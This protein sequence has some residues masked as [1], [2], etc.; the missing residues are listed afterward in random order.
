MFCIIDF[1]P[2]YFAMSTVTPLCIVVHYDIYCNTSGIVQ[3]LSLLNV[4]GVRQDQ[5]M[6][7]RYV[8]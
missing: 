4:F 2:Q 6:T 5:Y 7:V 8:I 1:G 3:R